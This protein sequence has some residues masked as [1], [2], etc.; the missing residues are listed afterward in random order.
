MNLD[1]TSYLLGMSTKIATSETD[2]SD[3][4]ATRADILYPKTAYL[5]NGRKGVGT[6]QSLDAATYTPST[7]D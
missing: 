4:T 6:I 2:L 1:I 3:A 5:G 7:I